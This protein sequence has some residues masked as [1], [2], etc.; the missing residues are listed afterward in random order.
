MGKKLSYDNKLKDYQ[1]QSGNFGADHS[2]LG[3][4]SGSV[5]EGMKKMGK[6]P[7][8]KDSQ[9]LQPSLPGSRNKKK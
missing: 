1:A 8:G 9:G 7:K 6:E 4:L 3:N 2:Y 5:K